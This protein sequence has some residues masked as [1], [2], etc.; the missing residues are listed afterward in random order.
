M[1]IGMSATHKRPCTSDCR[2]VSQATPASSPTLAF[3]VS[4]RAMPATTR[5][6]K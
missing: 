1:I 6:V 5:A 2:L 3:C 4:F